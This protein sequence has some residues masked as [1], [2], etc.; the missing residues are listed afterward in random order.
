MRIVHLNIRNSGQIFSDFFRIS[1][2]FTIFVWG[3]KWDHY[4]MSACVAFLLEMRD[5]LSPFSTLSILGFSFAVGREN[6][7]EQTS[8]PC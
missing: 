6:S 3:C 8:M 7:I 5:D 2:N 4:A 1:S